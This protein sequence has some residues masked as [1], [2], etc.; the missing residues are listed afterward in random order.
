MTSAEMILIFI[1]IVGLM[2][3][4]GGL[5]VAVLA[6]LEKRRKHKK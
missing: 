3:S 1:G 6:F 5:I 4:F 2:V